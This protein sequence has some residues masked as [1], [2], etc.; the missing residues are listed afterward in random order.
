MEIL[1]VNAANV[2]ILPANA[3][4]VGILPTNAANLIDGNSLSRPK[5]LIRV[6]AILWCMLN[7]PD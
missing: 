5:R 1:P 3:A 6:I 4:N 7:L 2:G